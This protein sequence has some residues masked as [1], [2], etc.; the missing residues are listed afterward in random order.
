[1]VSFQNVLWSGVGRRPL[2]RPLTT[3]VNYLLGGPVKPD[4]A[5]QA[6]SASAARRAPGRPSCASMPSNT[7]RPGFEWGY[8][9]SGPAQLAL[10][11]LAD[12][13][14]DDAAAARLH[15]DFKWP[16]VAKF[17]R[18]R[19]LLSSGPIDRW[20]SERGASID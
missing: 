15:R 20:L 1:M 14:G 19:W 8:S 2:P 18:A 11:I 9:G 6:R 17:N 7:A 10:A 13:F 12:H 4:L 5:Q 16:V 3:N